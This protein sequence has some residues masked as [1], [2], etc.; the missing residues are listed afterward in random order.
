MC[1]CCKLCSCSGLGSYSLVDPALLGGLVHGELLGLEPEG[2][3][4]VGRLDGVGAVTDV[5]ADLK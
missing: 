3:L 4:V 2:D 5:A 1:K